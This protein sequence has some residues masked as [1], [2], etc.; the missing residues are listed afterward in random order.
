MQIGHF[1]RNRS[2]FHILPL[3]PFFLLRKVQSQIGVVLFSVSDEAFKC[4]IGIYQKVVAAVNAR[5]KADERGHGDILLGSLIGLA[6]RFMLKSHQGSE[7]DNEGAPKSI[8]PSFGKIFTAV[9]IGNKLVNNHL[10]M[11]IFKTASFRARPQ[12]RGCVEM[13]QWDPCCLETLSCRSFK[14]TCAQAW[15]ACVW[16]RAISCG[17]C[18]GS[19]PK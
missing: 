4:L 17:F 19:S 14:S 13:A 9:L 18:C 7:L 2:I 8:D 3:S 12:R 10:P 5:P 16:Q 15:L 6:R 1:S 11:C